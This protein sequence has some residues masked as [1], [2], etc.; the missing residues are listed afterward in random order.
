MLIQRLSFIHCIELS[1]WIDRADGV[2]I[3]CWKCV[4]EITCSNHGMITSYYELGSV[5]I[6]LNPSR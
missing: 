6:C 4:R 3:T 5:V 1:M 2:G